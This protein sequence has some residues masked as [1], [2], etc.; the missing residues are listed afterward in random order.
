MMNKGDVLFFN[1]EVIHGVAP[2]DPD[3]EL[4][5][6][7]FRGRWSMLASTIKTVA[8]KDTPNSI[9]LED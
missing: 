8:D 5:W 6:L 3:E 4:D 2:V 9:Q 7:S 1:A